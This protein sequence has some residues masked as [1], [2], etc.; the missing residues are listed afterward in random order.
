ME[1]FRGESQ[2]VMRQ[3]VPSEPPAPG[4][5]PGDYTVVFPDGREIS[6]V[7]AEPEYKLGD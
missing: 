6:A 4:S 2:V 1:A 7:A 5:P 3:P